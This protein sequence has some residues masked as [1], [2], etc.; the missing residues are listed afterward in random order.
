ML[1]DQ[2]GG[3]ETV[4]ARHADVEQHQREVVLHQARERFDAGAHA[5][6]I[7]AEL[8]EDRFVRQQARRLV[9]DQQDVDLVTLF[10]VRPLHHP[11][12]QSDEPQRC[13][14]IRTSDSS[15]SVLTGLAT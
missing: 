7:L 4:H 8:A 9:V 6:Q 12:P 2:G 14:H 15:C 5:D 3:F 10:F 1:V 11:L 13:S